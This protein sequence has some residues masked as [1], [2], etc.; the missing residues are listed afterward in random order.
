MGSK[1]KSSI[2]HSLCC[3]SCA[4]LTVLMPGMAVAQQAGTDAA[5]MA[6]I[7]V[8][9]E[10]KSTVLQRVPAAVTSISGDLLVSQGAT[11]LTS[12]AELAPSLN[13][14]PI[15]T[16]TNIFIRGV[17]QTLTSPGSDPSVVVNINGAYVPSEMSG[18]SFYDISRVEV[19]PGPQ[20]TLYGRNSVG[21]VINVITRQPGSELSGEAFLEYGNFNTVHA[22]GAVDVPV[23]DNF[24]LRAA[25]NY[26]RHD[27]YYTNGVDD[28][29]TVGGRLTGVWTPADG[30]KITGTF[31]YNHDGGF[32]DIA[33]N[34]P[35]PTSNFWS[36][37]FDPKA[38]GLKSDFKTTIASLQIDQQISSNTD[39]TYIGSYNHLSVYQDAS[40]YA[41]PP[42]APLIVHQGVTDTSHELRVN[43]TLGNSKNVVG[44]Y[45]FYSSTPFD[46]VLSFPPVVTIHQGPISTASRGEAIF[47]QTTYE[48]A[49][50]LRFTGGLRYSTSERTMSGVNTTLIFGRATSILPYSGKM[51]S[52]HADW[53]VGAE[54][55][56]TPTS[57]LYANI[58]TG[59]SP[60]GFSIAPASPGST[61][62]A[63]FQPMKMTGYTIGTKNR[64]L[65]GRLTANLEGFYYDYSNY[66]ISQRNPS[67]GQ[68]QV[69]NAQQASSYGAQLEMDFNPTSADVLSLKPAYLR[70]IAQT[71]ITPAGNFNGEQLPYAPQWT[72]N[73]SYQHKFQLED[74]FVTALVGFQFVGS[75]WGFY[76][77][78]A[79]GHIPA[80]TQTNVDLSYHLPG[81]HWV[82]SLWARNLED[83]LVLTSGIS[84]AT[85]G[86]AAFFAAPPRTYGFRV[87]FN[88]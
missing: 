25:I 23:T 21:G 58:A 28:Q 38:A 43:N 74:G 1:L 32:G 14:E 63:S 40:F 66:Q 60:G 34:L 79:G 18:V 33:Q 22:F 65:D 46:G 27:G 36:L 13:I 4:V 41:G 67:T 72:V 31:S 83:S 16:E 20:G 48:A 10:K 53:K 7:V 30:T 84:G 37:A 44:L 78:A 52:Y 12:L 29:D 80:E 42:L 19:L 82:V 47:G 70:A 87:S 56:L 81:D 71:L 64:F 50:N 85:P 62:A 75:Q 77:H 76:T 51:N 17:G 69:Y 49:D 5:Q 54:Y 24:D 9:A 15:R 61:L 55:D 68:N 73:G 3:A 35:P 8:T 39:L 11:S 26:V 57:M 6:E 59:F 88:D 2:G 45:Y 86:P